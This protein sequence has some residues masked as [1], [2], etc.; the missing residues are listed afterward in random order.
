MCRA[1]LHRRYCETKR[2]PAGISER[3]GKTPLM[4][5]FRPDDAIIQMVGPI[6][7]VTVSC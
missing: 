4:A 6:K 3:A 2:D 5:A 7:M 1:G